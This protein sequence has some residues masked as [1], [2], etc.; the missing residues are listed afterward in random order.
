VTLNLISNAV[1]FT[2]EGEVQLAM[3]VTENTV[4]V[5]VSDTGIGV[6]PAEQTRVFDEFY[7]S[8]PAIQS[9][10]GGLGLG[11]AISRQ[12]VE[13]HG[14]S[15]EVQSPGDLRQGSTFS[16]CLPICSAP[17]LDMAL[18]VQLP[19][20]NSAVMVLVGH[21]DSADQLLS[22]LQERGFDARLCRVDQDE[23]WFSHMLSAT[24]AAIILGERLAA[25]EGWN[26]IGMLKRQPATE[27]ILVVAYSLDP[28][29]SLVGGT[30]WPKDP[31]LTNYSQLFNNDFFPFEMWLV[32]S[33]KISILSSALVVVATCL[34]GYALSR[35]RFAGRRSLM[36]AILILNIFPSILAI[37]ALYAMMQQF[38]LYIPWLGLDTH[39]ALILIYAAGATGINSLLVKSYIDAIPRELD[40]SA[41]VEGA[42]H[43]QTFRYIV[44]PMI[45]PIVITVGVLSFIASYGDFIIARVL[46][47]S[48]DQLT[49]MVGLLLFQT[50]RFDRDFGVITAGAVVA[51]L[52]I[53]LLYIP[54]QSYVISGLTA[55]SVKE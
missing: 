8:E 15:I 7:R 42:S 33:L 1:K 32:N 6:T 46:L 54:L 26:I 16:F 27:N 19:A 53:I 9:G 13:Q 39:G 24:P 35:F 31:G 4:R 5:S 17:N 41:L 12:L 3:S 30:L 51:A 23:T 11:L 55:G 44:F 34:S 10:H 45:I 36:I 14:G 38:G 29:K 52:P 43:W 28:A 22:F 25:R 50:D 49:V 47:K 21:D 2:N 48:A 37:V 20:Q 18:P 40:E